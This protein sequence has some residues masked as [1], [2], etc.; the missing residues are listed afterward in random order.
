MKYVLS[1][2]AETT[3]RERNIAPAWIEAA[4]NN[5]DLELPHD[6]DL[7]LR[8]YFKRIEA[9]EN[10]ILRLVVNRTSEAPVIVTAYFD[11]TMK[12]KL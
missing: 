6:T 4:L 9:V 12:G 5:A 8:Y 2:H 11:R 10:R 1:E 7:T 3:V